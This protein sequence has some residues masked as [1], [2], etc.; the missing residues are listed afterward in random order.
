MKLRVSLLASMT[1]GSVACGLV[2][3]LDRDFEEVA[4]LRER[5][6][7]DGSL[8]DGG[9]D[10]PGP[11]ERDGEVDAGRDASLTLEVVLPDLPGALD[12]DLKEAN[13][14]LLRANPAS[15]VETCAGATC[16]VLIPHARMPPE[17]ATR[18][19][20]SLAH[21]EAHRALWIAQ[22]GNEKCFATCTA[23]NPSS[24]ALYTMFLDNDPIT[25]RR[26]EPTVPLEFAKAYR[27]TDGWLV[28]RGAAWALGQEYNDERFAMYSTAVFA[29]DTTAI[30]PAGKL[31]LDRSFSG[32]GGKWQDF[33][34]VAGSTQRGDRGYAGASDD[35]IDVAAP[36]V[37]RGVVPT[38]AA[39]TTSDSAAADVFVRSSTT[40]AD[41]ILHFRNYGGVVT[42]RPFAGIDEKATNLVT[43]DRYVGYIHPIAADGGGPLELSVCTAAEVVERTCTP[44]KVPL[45]FSSITRIR[46]RADALWILGQSPGVSPR[47]VR[48]TLP[49]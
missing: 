37:R 46:T 39:M 45:P 9:L 43:T 23:D 36:T 44:A 14:L 28:G 22:K 40:A 33:V 48:L 7:A 11:S 6:C 15:R 13:I 8:P 10:S 31:T 2:A 21:L 17:D 12:F 20:A 4:C 49:M 18:T 41:T 25:M 19:A 27:S 26:E 34:F 30:F 47:I 16:T 29:W 32:P 5:D 24:A 35:F 38:L 1:A 3:G 42:T